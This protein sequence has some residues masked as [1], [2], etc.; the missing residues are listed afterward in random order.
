MF[1]FLHGLAYVVYLVGNNDMDAMAQGMTHPTMAHS[2]L[3]QPQLYSEN[4]FSLRP[5]ASALTTEEHSQTK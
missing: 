4:D 1:S 5:T 3:Q 2:Q